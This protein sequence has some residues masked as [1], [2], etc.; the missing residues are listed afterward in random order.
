MR[1][2]HDLYFYRGINVRIIQG[3]TEEIDDDMSDPLLVCIY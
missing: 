1:I 3:I 2:V